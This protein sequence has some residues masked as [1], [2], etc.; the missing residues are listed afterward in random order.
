MTFDWRKPH[1]GYLGVLMLGGGLYLYFYTPWTKTGS[2]LMA[3]SVILIGDEF[4]QVFHNDQFGGP[5][6]KLYIATLYQISWIK[7]FDT[8]FNKLISKEIK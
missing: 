5:I 4:Y 8:W 6:H 2:A 7:S 1:H 3:F